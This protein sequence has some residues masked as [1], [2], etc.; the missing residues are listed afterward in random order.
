MTADRHE[1]IRIAAARVFIAAV[2]VAA[3]G[4]AIVATPRFW[5]GAAVGEIGTHVLAGESYKMDALNAISADLDERKTPLRPALLSKAAIIR[6][7]FAED[8]IGSSDKKTVDA[9]LTSL[10]E[11]VDDALMNSP[12]DAFLW[13]I[14]SWL[15]NMRNGSASEQFRYLR[16]SYELGPNEAWIALRRIRFALAIFSSLPPDLAESMASEFVGLVRSQLYGEVTDILAGPAWPNRHVLL[17]R[18]K[19][20]GET[21]R[22]M[23]AKSLYDRGLDDF[24]VP[25]VEPPSAR[26]W[27]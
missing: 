13:L 7:R 14:R 27:R 20:L 8:S 9:R 19:D 12:S 22:R 1:G 21:E 3:M 4:W 5:S 16:I 24:T 10:N 18:L 2:A 11:A 17:A 6:L 25:G 26:P 15:D 23:V